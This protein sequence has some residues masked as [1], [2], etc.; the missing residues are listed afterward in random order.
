MWYFFSLFKILINEL[1]SFQ[2]ARAHVSSW[3]LYFPTQGFI[4]I[5][6]EALKSKISN[7]TKGVSCFIWKWSPTWLF[8]RS[9]FIPPVFSLVYRGNSRSILLG[10]LKGIL[11]PLLIFLCR[12]IRADRPIQQ[13]S[14]QLTILTENQLPC[15]FCV[16]LMMGQA[17]MELAILAFS[18]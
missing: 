17:H 12:W 11:S 18:P 5:P 7:C 4:L 2:G 3:R 15:L 16:D 10:W 9:A 13:Y 14:T 6:G 8:K 1:N